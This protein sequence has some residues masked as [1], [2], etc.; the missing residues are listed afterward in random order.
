MSNAKNSS[1]IGIDLGTTYSAVARLDAHGHPRTLTNAEGD[2]LTP[3][4]LFFEE[5][6]V[7]V[8]REALK[9]LSTDAVN[10]A[11][12]PKRELGKRAYHKEFFGQSFAPE[13]LQ[14][15]ILSKLKQDAERH[16]GPFTDA[17]ITVPAYFDEVRRKATQDAGYM[18]GLNVID[19]LNEPT[20]A[21]LAFGFASGFL[22]KKGESK[23][24]Q[25]VLVYDLGGGT[26][27]VTLMEIEGDRFN[28]LGTDGD[29]K[30]G[31]KDWDQRLVDWVAEEFIRR[32]GCDPREDENANGKLWRECE[33]AK[34]TLTS[35][36]KATISCDFRGNW[37]RL[38]VTRQQFEDITRDLLERT[39][40]TT[41]AVIRD[42]ELTWGDIDR[43]LLVGGSSRMPMVSNMLAELSGKAPDNSLS[44][45]E[46][47]AHGAA[48][49][50]GLL[51]AKSKGEPPAFQI[52]N[53]NSHSLGV[54]AK[55]PLTGEKM[56]ARLIK[57]NTPLPAQVTRTFKTH[58]QGQ[59]SILVQIIEGE[60]DDPD[61]CS[62]VGRCAVWG[63]PPD[64]KVG[65]AIRVQF[66]YS[67]NGR[68]RVEVRVDGTDKRVEH[69]LTR[70][71]FMSIDELKKWRAA[72]TGIDPSDVIIAEPV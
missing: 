10:V 55:K 28:T 43:V 11:D 50:A 17:V 1:P 48:L 2:L 44:P 34:R 71:N 31:G 68:L 36:T 26:F 29:F 54:V 12:C 30:L 58:K 60:N 69:E 18:A 22:N 14:A 25:R 49:R 59:K 21:A 38:D 37:V 70:E 15:M 65:T 19:I 47:V 41:N 35:R 8:G 13:V 33:E 62:Q 66:Q 52:R 27:D 64:L 9:A 57:R 53:V 7:I 67:E 24:K 40:F 63:L 32:F 23:G 42:A 5:G 51:L 45:D 46:A 4:V 6:Q 20:A 56:N 16:V 72:I 3:S 39:S 61:Q